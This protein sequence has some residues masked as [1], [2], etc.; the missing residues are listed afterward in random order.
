MFKALAT[1]VNLKQNQKYFGLGLLGP[2]PNFKDRE[3]PFL[4][5]LLDKIAMPAWFFN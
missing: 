1:K 2:K 3:N 5:S 4:S